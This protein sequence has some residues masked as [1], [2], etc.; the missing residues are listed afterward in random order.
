MIADDAERLFPLSLGSQGSCQVGGN[1]ATNAGGV[2]VL[3]YG[4]ARELTLGLEVVLAD[5]QVW[6]GLRSL[7]KDNTGYDLRDLFIG[8]E[9]T[10]GIITAA[11]L[12]IFPKPR[13]V[14]T[15]FVGFDSLGRIPQ[16]FKRAS[17]AAG[18][19][20]TAFEILPNIGIKFVLRHSEGTRHP[21]STNFPWYALLE[22][23]DR[24][25][26]TNATE[27]MEVILEDALEAEI[28]ADAA[29]AMSLIQSQHFWSLRE[30]MSEVQR[31]EGGSI[32]SDVS[33]PVT[34]VV[35]FIQRAESVVQH[36]VPGARPVPFGHFGD[37]NIHYNISQPLG[38]ERQEFLS[39]WDRVTDA[40]NEIVLDLNGSISAEHGIGRLKRRV[41][42][43]VKS[44]IELEM[45]RS[46]KHA[47][48]PKGILSPGRIL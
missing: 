3:A 1:L 41:L 9:G 27:T 5:G 2:A 6:D 20:L 42:A 43:D 38:A 44:E 34:Q 13:S 28:I 35:E 40:I 11:V 8:S 39:H 46:I 48:D 31:L 15:A 4:N 36:L 32:K 30:R 16:L 17:A 25:T 45:M 26:S 29:F 14:S 19:N 12:K 47:L 21:L 7:R 24:G 37:G 10:L 22:I 33:V 18:P 23:S